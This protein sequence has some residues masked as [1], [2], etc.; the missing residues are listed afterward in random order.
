SESF[1]GLLNQVGWMDAAEPSHDACCRYYVEGSDRLLLGP[2]SLA[3]FAPGIPSSAAAFEL[4]G[5]GRVAA[6]ETPAGRMVRVVF[7]YPATT[8]AI[9]RATAF[10]RL[11]GAVVRRGGK[12]VGLI[13]DPRDDE[14]ADALLNDIEII[15]TEAPD[16]NSRFDY[17]DLTLDRGM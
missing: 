11:P 2:V 1:K 16:W 6:F 15:R 5:K 3:R 10:R 8:I 7:E 13:F 4:G 14:Q 9:D 17:D 12:R